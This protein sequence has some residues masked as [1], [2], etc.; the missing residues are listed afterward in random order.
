VPGSGG[1][2][3]EGGLATAEEEMNGGYG[4]SGIQAT[5][6]A[7]GGNGGGGGQGT[8]NG[9]GVSNGGGS[10]ASGGAA[11]ATTLNKGLTTGESQALAY[12]T[13]GAGGQSYGTE[14]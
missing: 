2:G 1:D 14:A 4:S 10:G 7:Q 12:A 3:G 6:T 11:T 9:D 8:T 5:A 13:G